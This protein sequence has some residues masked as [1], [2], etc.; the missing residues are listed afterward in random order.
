MIN[1]VARMTVSWKY[2]AI[3]TGIALGVAAAL[4][5]PSLAYKLSPRSTNEER[6]LAGITSNYWTDMERALAKMSLS[7]FS[8]PVHEEITNR[9]YGC[10]GDVCSGG[11]STTAPAAVLAGVRWNDDPPFRVTSS[12]NPSSTCKRSETIRFETQPLC[13]VALFTAAEKGAARG[14][15]YG[16]GDAMLYR[17]HFGDLQFLHSMAARDGESA[18]ETKA[19][20]MGWFEMTWRAGQGEY[21]LDT[22]LREL[23]I[24]PIHAVFG[25][26]EW[27]MLD[28]YTQGSGPGLRRE[29]NDVAFGSLLHALEDSFAAGHVE[30]EESSGDGTCQAGTISVVAPGAIRSFHAYN[31][32]DH[33]GHG[34]ADSRAAFMRDLQQTGHVVQVGRGLV[35]ARRL[36]IDWAHVAPLFDCLFTLQDPAAEAGPG[37]FVTGN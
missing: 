32:Q 9:M 27:R 36:R 37:D 2:N 25:K 10:E 26:T 31:H 20:L 13:W 35:K 15:D 33:A 17:T 16:P 6:R 12:Q 19:K 5:S 23:P 22:R 14:Q 21:S 29:F 24:G 34:V 4:V 3:R 8:E 11:Q 28:L 30:R 7:G 18:S 1:G